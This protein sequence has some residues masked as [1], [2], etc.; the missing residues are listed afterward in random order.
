[1]R[2]TDVTCYPVWADR[3]NYVFLVVDTDEGLYG[4]GEAGLSRRERAIAGVVEHF[5]PL[6]IGQ[7]P[8]R[9]EHLWQVMSRGGFFPHDR[10]VGSAI[11]AI[12]IALW[13]L[14]AK[15]FGVPLYELLGGLVRESVACYCHLGAPD[16]DGLV[17]AARERVAEGWKFIRWSLQGE[18]DVLEPT[19]AIRRAI[20]EFEALR[21]ALG[22]EVELCF[23]VHTRL[24][25]PEAIRL[26]REIAR[27]RPFFVE[28]PIRSESPQAF[29][30]LRGRI[31]VPLAAGEQ[32]AS[33]WEFRE[34]I[35]HDLIDYA[36]VDLCIAGGLTEGKKIAGWCEGH[37]ID[38]AVHNPLGPVSTAAC[39]HY[40]LAVPNFCVQEQ[41]RRPGPGALAAEIVGGQPVW[42]DG[43]LLPPAGP[44]LGLTFDREAAAASPARRGDHP[45]LRRQDGAFTNW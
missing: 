14:K 34:L 28:D 36:R 41:P 4:L 16:I 11:A 43:S 6:L 30:A 32:F 45:R 18:G 38:M 35:D 42:E 1:M 24:S 40:N 8:S 5:K 44:G 12:D 15:R 13:D 19:P 23:D 3:R 39:L 25:P 2:I 31:D 33:K 21:G 10:V 7:D 37:Y 29:H 27:Y 22:D 9:T 20:C 26:C 17:A